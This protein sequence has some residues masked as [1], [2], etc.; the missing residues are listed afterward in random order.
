MTINRTIAACVRI[1]AVAVAFAM[2]GAAQARAQDPIRAMTY[3]IRLDTASDGANAWPHRRESVVNLIRFYAPDLFGMQ[4]VVPLQRTQLI[5]DLPEYGFIGVGR[6]D[7][8]ESGEFSPVAYRRDRFEIEASGAFW[9]SPTPDRPSIG[10]DAGYRRLVTWARLRQRDGQPGVLALST[11]WDHVGVRARAESARIIRT[12]L[13]RNRQACEPVVLM[14]DLNAHPDERSYQRLV[15]GRR[16]PLRDTLALSATAPFG[17]R[18]TF[19]GFDITRAEPAPIDYILVSEGVGVERHAVITQ[20]ESGRLPS[21]HYPV[22]ADLV[23]P[24]GSC[25]SQSSQTPR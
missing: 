24:A 17:P 23:L 18:G 13:A 20:H 11:H 3:N 8:A 1:A 6:D 9:L 12:W 10:W 4:E 14:G 25:G 7:G 2:M 15:T 5:E 16:A 22:F 21:D 19:N